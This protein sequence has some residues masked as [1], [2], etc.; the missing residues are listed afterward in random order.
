MFARIRR[1]L[2]Q[3]F[4]KSRTINNEPLNKVS[5]IVIILIDIF[6][7]F[8][9]FTGLDDIS[10]WYISPTEAYPCY[11]E[12]QDYRTKTTKDK[13]YEIVRLSLPSDTNN[14]LSFQRN[15][16][17]AE[18]GHLG[19]VSKTC[20]QYADYKDKINNPEKQQLIRNIDQEQ[21]K[22]STFEQENRT[23]QAQYDSTLLEKIAG[24]GREQSINQVSA[25]KAKQALQQNNRQ[26]S[27]FKQEISTLKNELLGKAESI[28]FIAFLKD[29]NQFR[30]VDKGYHQAS[31]W[32]PSIQLA[33]QALFLLPLIIVALSVHKFAQRRGYGLI[34]LIS[35]HLL[36]IFFIPLIIKIFEFL[37]IGAIFKFIFDIISVIFVG[38][39]FL[40]NYVYILM[41]PI[42]GFGI[43]QF[44]QKF[45][46]NAKVQAASRVQKSRCVNCAKKIQHLDTYCPHCG[47]DQYIECQNC[48]NLTYK[49]LSYC[50]H[51]GTSQDSSNL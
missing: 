30:E 6:I 36:V 11:S 7:L 33:F 48:H 31:F 10:R 17:Q 44:F 51:C 18:V 20:L 9:V 1:L 37:Q 23:I 49:H 12:W 22:I 45:V 27:T 24:Q 46:F 3:F 47:Y 16:Q 28:S 43:I 26:I 40:I 21:A 42:I 38:L 25:E 39:L 13:D 8:N 2:S 41:I 5:L 15:Y 32:Y 14:Q 4:S 35:W 29:N 19:K 34:S 50:K